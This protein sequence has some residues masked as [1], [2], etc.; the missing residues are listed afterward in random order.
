MINTHRH[1]FRTILFCLMLFPGFAVILQAQPESDIVI[2]GT[3]DTMM[4]SWAS[5]VIAD[6][7]VTYPFENLRNTVSGADV[8]FTNLEA[9]F[10]TP[11]QHLRRNLPFVLSHH[12]F[13]CYWMAE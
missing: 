6:S 8:F 2:L 11:E 1:Y 12:W 5:Q 4:G 3:G 13:R 10:G 7:G 9:P